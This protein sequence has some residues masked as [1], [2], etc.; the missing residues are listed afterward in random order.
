MW[1]LPWASVSL[2][3]HQRKYK[4]ICKIIQDLE[5]NIAV[6]EFRLVRGILCKQT[7]AHV[8]PLKICLPQDLVRSIVQF[9]HD[10]DLI[11]KVI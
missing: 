3:E 1:P 9:Y 4:D 11:I 10:S 8:N 2:Q 6:P 7:K 5:N